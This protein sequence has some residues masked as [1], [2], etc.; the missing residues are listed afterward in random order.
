MKLE[1]AAKKNPSEIATPS[2]PMKKSEPGPPLPPTKLQSYAQR[3][4]VAPLIVMP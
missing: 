2:P 4:L 1:L 3:L